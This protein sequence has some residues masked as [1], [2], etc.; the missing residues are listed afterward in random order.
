MKSVRCCSEKVAVTTIQVPSFFDLVGNEVLSASEGGIGQGKHLE[1]VRRKV[2]D[3]GN[4]GSCIFTGMVSQ[5]I[6][7]IQV[8]RYLLR[9]ILLR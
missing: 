4:A 7:S 2:V 1:K 3:F 9:W 8:C 5:D 6:F